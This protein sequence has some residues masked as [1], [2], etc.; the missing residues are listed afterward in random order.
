MTVTAQHVQK[1]REATGAGILDCQ[2]ALLT[3]SGDF[4]KAIQ[5]LREKGKA[6]A[7]QKAGRVTNQGLVTCWI[8]PD[9]TKGSIIEISCE[10]DFV[11]RTKEFQDLAKTLAQH[12]LQTQTES[13]EAILSTKLS[14]SSETVETLLKEKIG[15]L[16]ENIVIKRIARCGKG[17]QSIIGNY[18]HAPHEGAPE[19]GKLG[20]ILEAE[21]ETS[22]PEHKNLARE[23]C[24]QIAAASP[25]WIRKEDVPAEI[26]EKEKAIY[27]EQCKQSGK[28]EVAWTKIMEGK[29]KDFYKQFCLLEQ[30]YIRD[31]S[32]KTSVQQTI[33]SA[34]Q[35]K[36][37]SFLIKSFYRFKLGES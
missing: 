36:P 5:F 21:S 15:K 33:A 31:S 16:G 35:G 11:A 8:S 18:V 30:S 9:G 22:N 32:G 12:V 13:A 7:A 2:K 28:P 25:K 20:V 4:E 6:S 17:V 19:S 1:L 27:Q 26:V 23:L 3:S 24:M 34:A 10:T 29:L 37:D 14:G